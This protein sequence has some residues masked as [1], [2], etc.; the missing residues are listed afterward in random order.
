M[1]G[2]SDA[3]GFCPAADGADD[4]VVFFAE[5]IDDGGRF[6]AFDGECGQAGGEVGIVGGVDSDFG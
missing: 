3:S 5:V 4:D 1:G 2:D 6:D